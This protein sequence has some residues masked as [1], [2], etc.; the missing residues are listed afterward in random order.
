MEEEKAV[1]R[2]DYPSPFYEYASDTPTIFINIFHENW[3]IFE[4]PFFL[5]Q[6]E[7]ALLVVVIWCRRISTNFLKNVITAARKL[8]APGRRRH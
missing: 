6:I 5:R 7:A 8:F 4:E 3:A 2:G 1:R